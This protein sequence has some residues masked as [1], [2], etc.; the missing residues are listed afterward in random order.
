LGT[1]FERFSD[2]EDV[3]G[4][5]RLERAELACNTI[6]RYERDAAIGF[7]NELIS[8]SDAARRHKEAR[9]G[10]YEEAVEFLAKGGGT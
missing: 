10:E 7:Q 6:E 9:R 4:W 1:D 8:P 3:E 2:R 5:G